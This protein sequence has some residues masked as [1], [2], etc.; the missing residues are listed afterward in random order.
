MSNPKVSFITVNFNQLEVTLEMIQSI[1]DTTKIPF[2][3]IVVDNASKVDP[4]EALRKQFPEVIYIQS[5]G[6]LGFAKANNLGVDASKGDYLFFVNN[7]TELTESLAQNLAQ[8]LAENPTVGAVSPLICYFP[9]GEKGAAD[10]IQYAGTTELS[11]WTG[12]NQTIGEKEIDRGQFDTPQS[13]AYAHGAAMMVPRKVVDEVGA[14]PEDFFLYYEELDW[15]AQIKKAGY[16][17]FVV[18]TTK[19]YHKESLTIGPESPLKVFYIN[20][21][22][23]LFMRRNHSIRSLIP[24]FVFLWLVTYPKNIVTYLLRGKSNLM[25]AFHRGVWWN[26]FPNKIGD[27]YL[28]K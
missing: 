20:R 14:W 9:E 16:Q 22:R 17:I 3:I 12:R 6:N 19:I 26:L 2:E 24:Y 8:F 28:P 4:Q 21:N 18:P 25:K 7:D 13:T 5:G 15:C 11:A 1:Y 10:V 27:P 23:V